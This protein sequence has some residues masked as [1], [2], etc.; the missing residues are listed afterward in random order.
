M[1][2]TI[3]IA[4][5]ALL[6]WGTAATADSLDVTSA[7]AMGGVAD[8]MCQGDMQPGPCGLEVDHD[9]TS[10]AF[11]TDN[12]PD[13]ESIYR[14]EFLFDPNDISPRNGNWR[15]V[16]F[17]AISPNPNPGVNFCAGFGAN[18]SAF[19]VFLFVA[20]GGNQYA[21]QM[22]A[23]GNSCGEVGVLPRTVIADDEPVKVCVEYEAAGGGA[24]RVAL[25]VVDDQAACPTSGDP[26]WTERTGFSNDGT[27]INLVQIGTP[28]TNNFARGEDGPL[29][30]DEFASF[31]TIAP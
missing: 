16:I 20:N 27:E 6:T 1:K 4:L 24:G 28:T 15:Q 8:Q 12:T 18:L 14:A 23:R 11:L 31:R 10:A 3:F 9:N 21:I 29:Y 30:F 25:A 13:G 22:Y 17:M 5:A 7:A 26:E 19:R 2:K